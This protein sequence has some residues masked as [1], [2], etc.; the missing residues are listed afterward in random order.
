MLHQG[1]QILVKPEMAEMAPTRIQDGGI[2]TLSHLITLGIGRLK[3]FTGVRKACVLPE[4]VLI[5]AN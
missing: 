5:L 2:S 1:D 3:G 4:S